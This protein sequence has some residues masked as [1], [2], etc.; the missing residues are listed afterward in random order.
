[1]FNIQDVESFFSSKNYQFKSGFSWTFSW[2]LKMGCVAGNRNLGFRHLVFHLL[3]AL[4]GFWSKF[5]H[6]GGG[7]RQCNQMYI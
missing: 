1:M 3:H 7:W 5:L 2:L 4:L 6:P